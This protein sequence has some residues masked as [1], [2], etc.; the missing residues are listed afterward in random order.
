ENLVSRNP[1]VHKI[2]DPAFWANWSK[3]PASEFSRFL[4]VAERGKPTP[5]VPP[6]E[7]KTAGRQRIDDL[8]VCVRYTRALLQRLGGLRARKVLVVSAVRLNRADAV[9][10]E[11]SRGWPPSSSLGRLAQ[12]AHPRRRSA[13]RNRFRLNLPPKRGFFR[14]RRIFRL[15]ANIPPKGGNYRSLCALWARTGVTGVASRAPCRRESIPVPRARARAA[16]PN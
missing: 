4:A 6:P 8:E 1:R 2:Y 7:G 14:L 11:R 10:R 9:S 12:R 15:K 3:M 13:R 16:P 5:A